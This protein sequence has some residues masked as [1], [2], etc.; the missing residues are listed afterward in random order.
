MKKTRQAHL[1]IGLICSIFILMESITGLLMNEPW[2]I[3]QSQTEGGNMKQ[4]MMMQQQGTT[5][6]STQTTGQTNQAGTTTQANGTTNN[7]TTGNTQGTTN[8]QTA[9]NTQGTT[10]GQAP[11]FG[12][13]GGFSGE[14]SQSTSLMGIIRGLHEGKIGTT[15]ITWLIDL[16]AI[17]MIFLTGSG[18]YLSAKV[19][20]ADR[21]R[22]RL[23]A[24]REIA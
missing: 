15:D 1:W 21:K 19:L 20:A 14:G 12:G 18:I 11:A 13:R 8:N 22:K 23:K 17:A 3:G 5:T 4:G 9:G 6:N 16:T 7:Q 10:N 24:E 2:L